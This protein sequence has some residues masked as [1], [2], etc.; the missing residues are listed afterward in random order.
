MPQ[1]PP[2]YCQD[3]AQLPLSNRQVTSEFPPKLP[4]NCPQLPPAAAHSLPAAAQVA[5]S[6]QSTP[7]RPLLLPPGAARM[8][9]GT[10]Q[11]QSDYSSYNPATSQI[12][13]SNRPLL[14]P[15]ATAPRNPMAAPSR[16]NAMQSSQICTISVGAPNCRLR[17]RQFW[18]RERSSRPQLYARR[19]ASRANDHKANPAAA[20]SRNSRPQFPAVGRPPGPIYSSPGA[21]VLNIASKT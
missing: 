18:Q 17:C 20:D 19:S 1:L 16:K 11:L 8:Q 14:P 2:N 5:P 4:P 13:T 7:A 6:C 10:A 15:L 21:A 9:P 3:T 12:L